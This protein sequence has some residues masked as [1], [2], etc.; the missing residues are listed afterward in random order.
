LDSRGHCL[1]ALAQKPGA[2]GLRG[3][4]EVGG[5]TST[6]GD[7][8][9]LRTGGQAVEARRGDDEAPGLGGGTFRTPQVWLPTG[10]LRWGPVS[11]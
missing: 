1:F 6:G 11:A 7:D 9:F 4:Q 3:E 2:V 5:A 10:P 8:F